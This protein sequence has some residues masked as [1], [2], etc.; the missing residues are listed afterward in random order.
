MGKITIYVVDDHKMFAT[1]IASQINGRE[2]I[3]VMGIVMSPECIEEKIKE[4]QPDAILMDIRMGEHNGLK[5]S[6]KIK[7]SYP[8]I[9][10]ILMSGYP[11]GR[12]AKYSHA[13]GFTSK[14]ESV[15]SLVSTIK[16]ICMENVCIFPE[17]KDEGLTPTE[18]KVLNKISKDMTRKEIAAELYMSEKTVSNHITS[19]LEKLQVRSR[20]GAIVKGL[21][22]G[23]IESD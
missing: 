11:I 5:L 18:R 17:C 15:D 20:V 8:D 14:E 22:L 6:E 4:Y 19:I 3:E 10:V 23:I 21:E 2:G 12:L 9:K 7:A 13:D 1:A 16:K